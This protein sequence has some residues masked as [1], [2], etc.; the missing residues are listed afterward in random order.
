M[1]D[2]RPQLDPRIVGIGATSA[3][4]AG[5]AALWRGIAEGL[6]AIGPVR[7]FRTE[8]LETHI[9]AL[10][11][12]RVLELPPGT[13]GEPPDAEAQTAAAVRMAVAAA[14]EALR[15]A[16][17]PAEATVGMVLGTSH[18]EGGVHTLARRVAAAL[19]LDGPCLTVSTACASSTSALGPARDLLRA[20]AAD[21]ILLGGA[22]LLTLEIFAGF[23]RLGLL[24]TEPCGPFG[25]R[26]GT[27]LGEGAAFLVLVGS[28][29]A[30]GRR[31][32]GTVLGYGTANDAWHATT[33]DPTGKGLS[34]ALTAALADAGLAA[35]DVDYV[36]AHGTGT[37]ANDASEWRGLQRALGPRAEGIPIS[38]TKSILGHTQGAA[39]ALELATSLC[40]LAHGMVPPTRHH[41]APRPHAPPDVVA[42]ERP[43]PHAARHIVSCNAAFGGVNTAAVIA[44]P[45]VEPAVRPAPPRRSLRI[46]GLGAVLPESDGRVRDFDPRAAGLPGRRID[47]ATGFIAAAVRQALG[48]AEVDPTTGLFVVQPRLSPQVVAAF[49]ARLDRGL[50][51]LSPSIFARMVLNAGAGVCARL[52]DLHGPTSTMAADAAGGLFALVHAAELLTHDPQTAGML[53]AAT[54]ELPEEA[55][56]SVPGVEGGAAVHL[57]R[58]PGGPRLLAWAIAPPGRLERAVAEVRAQVGPAV[59]SP[60]EGLPPTRSGAPMTPL[61]QLSTAARR[62][63]RHLIAV[64][65]PAAMALAVIIEGVTP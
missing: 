35:D 8:G 9:A 11:P 23:D 51:A 1:I 4:G 36:N 27:T 5:R 47:P 12:D 65:D 53:V 58:G 57:D 56:E 18:L 55:E 16:A 40:A 63:G 14:R 52:F 37:R 26:E 6:D 19:E 17:I 24:C 46:A 31:L 60:A 61:W 64:D 2:P 30:A 42:G 50:A 13:P 20:G 29:L 44:G 49:E 59:V 43:R 10:V 34:R 38:A 54:D 48:E 21:V 22:D 3:F 15:D 45:S 33:P 7:R 39:G 41:H 32:W 25:A 28:A 62:P